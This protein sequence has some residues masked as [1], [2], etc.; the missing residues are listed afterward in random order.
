MADLGLLKNGAQTFR[1][2]FYGSLLLRM[3]PASGMMTLH[4]HTVQFELRI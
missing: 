1:I 3:E 2:G 4:T